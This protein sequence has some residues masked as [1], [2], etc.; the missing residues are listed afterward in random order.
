MQKDAQSYVKMCDKCQYFSNIIRQPTEELTLM[1][2]PWPFS[3]WGLDIV[4]PFPIVIL[5]LKFLDVGI[6]YF[7]KWVK[8]EPLATI[9]E[10]NVWSFV[11]KSIIC[12]F[13]IP[14]VF[15]S[16]NG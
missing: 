16:N 13:R 8:A 6:D 2:T 14:S 4:G 15:V 5:H 12:H 1:S 11:W 3:Q 9:T 7:I 10:K